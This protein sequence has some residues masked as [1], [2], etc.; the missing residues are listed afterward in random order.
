MWQ[1]SLSAGLLLFHV[2]RFCQCQEKPGNESPAVLHR[3]SAVVVQVLLQVSERAF[4]L[5]VRV[6]HPPALLS[7][8]GEEV[9]HIEVQACHRGSETLVGIM[10]SAVFVEAPVIYRGL[11]SHLPF[12]V[13]SL[14]IS[15]GAPVQPAYQVHKL[16]A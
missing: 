4:Y 15:L 6:G 1:E 14:E 8:E 13:V 9:G 12:P 7:L 16:S 5:V 10:H 2:Q 3:Q 11:P